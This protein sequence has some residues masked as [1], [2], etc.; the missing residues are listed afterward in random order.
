[1]DIFLDAQTGAN[2]SPAFSLSFEP[3]ALMLQSVGDMVSFNVQSA[4]LRGYA[5]WSKEER[6]NFVPT[7]LTLHGLLYSPTLY[8]GNQGLGASLVASESFPLAFP[9]ESSQLV[10]LSFHCSRS[11]LQIVEEKRSAN[12][13][14]TVSLSLSLWSSMVL[15]SK[16]NQ[17]TL[18]QKQL[19][20]LQSR[21][22]GPFLTISRS[23]WTDMLSSIGSPQRRA[24]ELP[25]L[26]TQQEDSEELKSAIAHVNEAYALFAQ[27]RY[28]EAVQGVPVESGQ[29]ATLRSE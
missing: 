27:D 3:E 10:S 16:T 19:L 22:M 26:V 5:F 12:P 18:S 24:I 14:P 1:M 21:Q 6:Q 28:R 8:Q 2:E 4:M 20:R 7:V 25:S 17:G 13:G 11:Y 9:S 15:L 23:H 29:K